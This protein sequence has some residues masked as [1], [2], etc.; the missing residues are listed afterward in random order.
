MNKLVCS[1]VQCVNNIGGF[2]TARVINVNGVLA[3]EDEDTQCGTYG[4][5]TL[6]KAIKNIGNLNIGAALEQSFTTDSLE[7]SPEVLCDAKN[8]RFNNNKKCVA[9]DILMATDELMPSKAPYCG[10]F[11]ITY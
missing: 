11:Q 8:C 10:T 7:M 9:P 6:T 2:C 3:G 5:R 4:E 1:G